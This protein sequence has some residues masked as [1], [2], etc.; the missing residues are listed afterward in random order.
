MAL[1]HG[2]LVFLLLSSYSPLQTAV[3]RPSSLG[4]SAA[5]IVGVAAASVGD[6]AV[7]AAFQSCQP[8]KGV[9]WKPAAAWIQSSLHLPTANI[10][11]R[12]DELLICHLKNLPLSLLHFW[13]V[14]ELAESH[15]QHRGQWLL[16]T[17]TSTNRFPFQK[18]VD[19]PTF[20]GSCKMSGRLSPPELGQ[21]AQASFFRGRKCDYEHL[22]T[23]HNLE[24]SVCKWRPT[25]DP[26]LSGGLPPKEMFT[27]MCMSI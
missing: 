17:S 11:S 1:V 2:S 16:R 24:I 23:L 6:S 3:I 4:W 8:S 7:A 25:L 10:F 18:S 27:W 21:S 13:T 14:K 15:W 5:A 22:W 26:Q 9:Q 20:C 19:F 12:R